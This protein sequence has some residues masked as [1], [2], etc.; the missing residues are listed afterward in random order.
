MFNKTTSSQFLK[1]GSIVSINIFEEKP[2]KESAAIYLKVIPYLYFYK[3]HVFINV[4]EGI[5]LLLVTD[6]NRTPTE[7]FVIHR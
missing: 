7:E 4:D 5:A 1:Y 3:N 6:S 2:Y